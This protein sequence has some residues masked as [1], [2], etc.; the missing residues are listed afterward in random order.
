MAAPKSVHLYMTVYTAACT[1]IYSRQSSIQGCLWM[2]I[3]RVCITAAHIN[4]E[5]HTIRLHYSNT[6]VHMTPNSI[7]TYIYPP[8]YVHIRSHICTYR[9]T[10]LLHIRS[11]IRTYRLACLV[12]IRSHIRTYRLAC[13]SHIRSHIG[14]YRLTCLVHIYIPYV[15]I[16]LTLYMCI[17][18]TLDVFGT[19]I[20]TLHMYIPHSI[21][22]CI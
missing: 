14:T 2:W 11:H 12:H 7:R 19:Y 20:Y 5:Y 9:L 17:Y 15:C 13:F 10:C 3:R 18:L 21:H 8:I 6:C 22:D 1:I 16:Y 4:L